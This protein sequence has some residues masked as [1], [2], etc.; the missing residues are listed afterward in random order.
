V[1]A[2]QFREAGFTNLSY[3]PDSEGKRLTAVCPNGHPLSIHLPYV[4]CHECH[5]QWR[6]YFPPR[7]M[8][9]YGPPDSDAT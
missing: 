3:E 9:G 4:N 1:T 6:A 7:Y 2:R 8:A 5:V